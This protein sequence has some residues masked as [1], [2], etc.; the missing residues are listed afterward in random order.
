MDYI[1]LDDVLAQG[2]ADEIENLM[3]SIQWGSIPYGGTEKDFKWA[4]GEV[5]EFPQHHFLIDDTE[6]TVIADWLAEDS[7]VADIIGDREFLD[8][9]FNKVNRPSPDVEQNKNYHGSPHIDSNA[10]N[11][12]TA[13]YYIND[14]SGDTIL[15]NEKWSFEEHEI[16]PTELT[17][18]T[19]VTPKKNRLVIFNGNHWHSAGVPTDDNTRY[20]LN[21][22]WADAVIPGSYT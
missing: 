9:K 2:R 10:P 7:R 6:H 21:L 5:L 8:G 17:L 13:I 16:L 18:M 20:V 3:N 11:L 19:R 1:V 14:A 12:L 15:F 4:E 22:G